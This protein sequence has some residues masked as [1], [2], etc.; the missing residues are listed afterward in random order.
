MHYLAL[1]VCLVAF[2]CKK[3]DSDSVPLGT[4]GLSFNVAGLDRTL[5][6]EEKSPGYFMVDGF[7]A[8]G[9]LEVWVKDGAMPTRASLDRTA[10]E[11]ELIGEVGRVSEG[12]DGVLVY[13]VIRT[14][15]SSCTN[16]E[17]QYFSTAYIPTADGAARCSGWSRDAKAEQ[18]VMCRKLVSSTKPSAASAEPKPSAAP[19]TTGAPPAAPPKP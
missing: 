18:L 9:L 8:S 5:L 19:P 10:H 15:C 17:A 4:S 2:G 13:D 14:H 11:D 1:A 7:A 3:K 16:G 6:I 12:S